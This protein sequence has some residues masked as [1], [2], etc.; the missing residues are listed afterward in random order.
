MVLRAGPA[1]RHWA[2]LGRREMK[3]IKSFYLAPRLVS[4]ARTLESVSVIK[5]A[6]TPPRALRVR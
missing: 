6:Q 5:K 3:K 2:T 1:D 4:T